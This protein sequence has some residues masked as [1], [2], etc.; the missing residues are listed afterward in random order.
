MCNQLSKNILIHFLIVLWK[1]DNC[2]IVYEE[3]IRSIIGLHM[4]VTKLTGRLK[5]RKG[6]LEWWR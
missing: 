2:P 4:E 1:F 3:T 6:K 5:G